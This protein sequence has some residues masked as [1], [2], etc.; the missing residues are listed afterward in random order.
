M[1]YSSLWVTT[2]GLKTIE[3]N[4]SNKNIKPPSSQKEVR[5]FIGL[6]N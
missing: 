2:N 6:V 1:E 4:A 3:K 5:Q